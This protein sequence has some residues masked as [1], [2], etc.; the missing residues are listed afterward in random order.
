MSQPA[1][2]PAPAPDTWPCPE[3]TYVNAADADECEVC[4]AFADPE[5]YADAFAIPDGGEFNDEAYFDGDGTPP[6][7]PVAA[8]PPRQFA[9][10]P[11][12]CAACTFENPQGFQCSMC[13]TPRM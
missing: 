4:G 5:G 8:G 11:W 10:G 13:G 7:S 12:A 9:A 6:L 2:P 3:C 1:A